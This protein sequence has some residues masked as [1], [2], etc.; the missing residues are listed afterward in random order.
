LAVY[1]LDGRIVAT[2]FSGNAERGTHTVTFDA[3]ALPSG[4]YF[5]RLSAP[6]GTQTRKMILGK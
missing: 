2:L 5:Y 1:T 6:Q 4:L 3:G